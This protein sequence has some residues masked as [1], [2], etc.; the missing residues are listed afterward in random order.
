[1]STKSSRRAALAMLGA[2]NASMHA[3]AGDP[4]L[5]GA[6]ND[7][8]DRTT[9]VRSSGKLTLRAVNTSPDGQAFEAI[10]R[11]GPA[12]IAHSRSIGLSVFAPTGIFMNGGHTG[13]EIH[14]Y[15]GA[16]VAV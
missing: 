9:W 5:A 4:L 16:G 3:A 13:M 15:G 7:A 10:A 1:M 14:A 8:G 11:V 12:I 6:I 2:G